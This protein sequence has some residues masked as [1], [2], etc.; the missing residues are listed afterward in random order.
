MAE[1]PAPT[2]TDYWKMSRAEQIEHDIAETVCDWLSGVGGEPLW[3]CDECDEKIAKG[4]TV[5]FVSDGGYDCRECTYMCRACV[6][7]LF[8]QD[9]TE[10]RDHG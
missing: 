6:R 8:S 2:Q 9:L 3:E 10:G 5:H 4:E 7:K 1:T